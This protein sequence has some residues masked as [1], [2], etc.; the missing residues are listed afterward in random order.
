MN[1][2]RGFG[3]LFGLIA[4]FVWLVYCERGKEYERILIDREPS[5]E[6]RRDFQEGKIKFLK[7]FQ[8]T[9]N[10]NGPLGE[11]V[12]PGEN[13]IGENILN[14]HT[15]RNRLDIS[16]NFHLNEDQESIARRAQKF[17]LSYNLE[18]L[19]QIQRTTRQDTEHD[20]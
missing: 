14:Q 13:T 11:W 12:I 18:M 20:R 5:V 1:Y 3:L 8:L 19:N 9:N 6:A 2:W 4:L 10:R 16:F 15:K 7:V 17:A